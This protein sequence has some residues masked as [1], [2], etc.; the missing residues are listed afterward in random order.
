MCRHQTAAALYSY[1]CV[2]TCLRPAA[3]TKL[4]A[5]YCAVSF[6]SVEEGTLAFNSGPG[7]GGGR[8]SIDIDFERLFGRGGG[9]EPPI[10]FNT[11]SWIGKIFVFGV[12]LII[13]LVLL[14][15][16]DGIYTTYLWFQSMDLA[17]V[18]V[19]RITAQIYTF[20][21]FGAVFLVL[22]TVNVVIARRFRKRSPVVP[23]DAAPAQIP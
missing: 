8:D 4:P 15:I 16:G 5:D 22:L 14:G 23:V 3:H 20:L 12:A 18:Y 2:R 1:P 21:I 19:T 13:V 9:N 11:P 17:S 6:A 7:R 10:T